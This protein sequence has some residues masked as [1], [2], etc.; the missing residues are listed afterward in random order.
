MLCTFFAVW[1]TLWEGVARSG[2]V[3]IGFRGGGVEACAVR[4]AQQLCESRRCGA[5]V[6]L[7]DF[8]WGEN[9]Q[10]ST[11][12][13]QQFLHTHNLVVLASTRRRVRLDGN[14][15]SYLIAY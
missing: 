15:S 7:S 1:D 11:A 6:E 5:K 12:G 14:M 2:L 10:C 8:I 13:G 9:K 4:V 3:L